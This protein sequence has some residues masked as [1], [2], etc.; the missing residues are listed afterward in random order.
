MSQRTDYQIAAA[1]LAERDPQL[2][3]AFLAQLAVQAGEELTAMM[4]SPVET[5]QVRQGRAQ[6]MRDLFDLTDGAVEAARRM[7]NRK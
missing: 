1:R 5:L 3:R 6:A 2:W 7:D 4:N